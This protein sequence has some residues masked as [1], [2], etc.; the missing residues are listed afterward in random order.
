MRIL[1]ITGAP[2]GLAADVPARTTGTQDQLEAR[3]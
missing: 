2:E 3:T 1:E